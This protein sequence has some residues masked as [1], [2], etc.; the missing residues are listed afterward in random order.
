MNAWLWLGSGCLLGIA[1]AAAVTVVLWRRAARRWQQAS[2]TAA[3]EAA[4]K[5]ADDAERFTAV[6][7]VT[8]GL[9]HE[10]KNPLSTIGLNLQLLR[11]SLE[12]ADIAEPHAGRLT[13]RID[14]LSGE[15]EHLRGILED[16]LRFAGR[17]QLEREPTDLNE[18]VEELVDF[19]AP[20]AEQSGVQL[21]SQLA[22]GLPVLE[23]DRSLLKQAVL[24]L[25]INA[26][27]AMVQARYGDKPHGGASDLIVR[28]AHGQGQVE[29]HVIDTGPGIADDQRERVFDP[30]VSTKKGGSGLG[31]PTARRIASEHG[32]RIDL[33]SE[34]GRGSDFVLSLPA[35]RQA[36][37]Q[38]T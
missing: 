11:E 38:A 1:V 6:A 26:T 36:A 32:G 8:A 22:G 31:L 19:Y 3:A 37:D 7:R 5:A 27:Q 10:I 35:T 9:A 16:F 23:V 33:H 20:Q 12:E 13:R 2:A 34:P 24:N 28:T 4:D 15:V 17:M 30:Y 14:A 29:L 21:R 18:L 25:M